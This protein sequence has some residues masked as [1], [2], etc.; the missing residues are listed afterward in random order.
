MSGFFHQFLQFLKTFGIIG[1]ALALVIGQA[2]TNMVSSLVDDI[3]N[4]FVGLFLP[5]GNLDDVQIN[6]VNFF[7]ATSTFKIG[8]LILGFINFVI[9]V[10]IIFFAYKFLSRF[11]LVEDKTTSS[12]KKE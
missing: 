7:G 4:P 11:K 10:V 5:A 8:N 9:I 6:I 2:S 1:L 12:V 3:I